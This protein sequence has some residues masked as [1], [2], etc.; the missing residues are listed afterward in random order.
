MSRRS[1][2][3][4]ESSPCYAAS[5]V[6]ADCSSREGVASVALA[7]DACRYYCRNAPML[8]FILLDPSESKRGV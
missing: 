4:G 1:L 5:E 3:H 7:E 2:I 8:G 6:K